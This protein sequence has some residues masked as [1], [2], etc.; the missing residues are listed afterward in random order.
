MTQL[1]FS[2]IPSTFSFNDKIWSINGRD[3]TQVG[4]ENDR[5]DTRVENWKPEMY[6]ELDI[7]H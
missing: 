7:K 4:K 3:F 1:E 5:M 6:K 2:K